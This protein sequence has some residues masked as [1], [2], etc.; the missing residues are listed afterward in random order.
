MHSLLL[1]CAFVLLLVA[2]IQGFTP[3]GMIIPNKRHSIIMSQNRLDRS[4]TSKPSR[5]KI[6]MMSSTK[7]DNDESSDNKEE[8]TEEVSSNSNSRFQRFRKKYFTTEDDGL[9]FKQRMA[10]A[11][12]SVVLSYGWVSN[13][14]YSITVSLAWYLFSK[15]TGLS[16]LAPGQW[17]GFLA[18]YAGFYV[19]NNVIRPLRFGMSVGVSVYFDRAIQKV[20]DIFQIKKGFAVFLTVFLVNVVGTCLLMGSGI[21][22]AST[23][24]KVPIWVPK[25]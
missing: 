18:I 20:Q 8:T 14:S 12:L 1:G 23:A 10:K 2:P 7:D 11:G 9:T 5:S 25:G 6:M 19:F 21:V 17:K 15:K 24:S 3:N 4:I 16:P 22:L 13:V